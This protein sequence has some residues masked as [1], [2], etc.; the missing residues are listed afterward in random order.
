MESSDDRA[1]AM[2]LYWQAYIKFV[3]ETVGMGHFGPNDTRAVFVSP[4]IASSVPAS[5]F[6]PEAVTNQQLYQM[7]NELLNP[8][9]GLYEPVTGS[10]YYDA[11]RE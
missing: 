4:S 7:V 9:S 3:A 2:D 1:T 8:A 5:A 6:I 10:S 11:V